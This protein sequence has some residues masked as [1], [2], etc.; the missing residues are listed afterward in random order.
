MKNK[1][2]TFVLI[3]I[4]VSLLMTYLIFFTK[5]EKKIVLMKTTVQQS[6]ME[7]NSEKLKMQKTKEKNTQIT[8]PQEISAEM[9]I[10]R[11]VKQKEVVPQKVIILEYHDIRP[12][13]KG[14]ENLSKYNY[15]TDP[16]IFEQ[17]IE[18]LYKNGYR[19]VTLKELHNLWEKNIPVKDKLVVLT[20]DDGDSGVYKYAYPILQKY[21]IHFVV[22]LITKHT[23]TGDNDF[24][25]NQ[26]QVQEMLD[27]GLCELGGHTVNHVDLS[28]LSYNEQLKEIQGCMKDIQLMFNYTPVSFCYPFNK[29]N[30]DSV[31]IVG[32][33]GY[34]MATVKSGIAQK[35]YNHLLLPRI[36]V[37][38]IRNVKDFT[39]I[40]LNYK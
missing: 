38:A 14:E 19:T 34:K 18:Y 21:N 17:E 24:Y 32:K 27:S 4:A 3:V 26:L 16:K 40:F 1:R 10:G 20:F 5:A 6:I 22:F 8:Q 29:Y 37:S 23:I 11:N 30:V 39:K 28:K 7:A 33:C 12:I 35:N 15:S 2:V 13:S 36:D 9:P 31:N 25:M